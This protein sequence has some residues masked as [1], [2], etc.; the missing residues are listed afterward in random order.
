MQKTKKRSKFS[1]LYTSRKKQEYDRTFTK[2][3]KEL[4]DDAI[5][6]QMYKV[7]SMKLTKYLK[8]MKTEDYVKLKVM[9]KGLLLNNLDII[10][11]DFKI[12]Y[13]N[14]YRKMLTNLWKGI[15]DLG[16]KHQVMDYLYL[17][18]LFN[19]QLD[20]VSKFSSLVHGSL[21]AE[22]A[23]GDDA[24]TLDKKAIIRAKVNLAKLQKNL[25]QL[26]RQGIYDDV[27]SRG[28][29]IA[30]RLT[31]EQKVVFLQTIQD[32]SNY[33]KKAEVSK[34][35]F[36]ADNYIQNRIR[37]LTNDFGNQYDSYIKEQISD[38]L[39]RNIE[40]VRQIRETFTKEQTATQ[41]IYNALVDS[42]VQDRINPG[43][44]AERILRTELSIAYNFGKL[45]GF[46][47]PEDLTKRFRWN[48][49]WELESRKDD[50]QVCVPCQD[51]DGSIWTVAQ[52]LAVGTRLDRGILKYV[53]NRG[54][55]DFKNPTLPMI[56]YHPHC[57]CYWT[58][59][60]NGY[61][62]DEG[63]IDALEP[64]QPTSSVDRLTA[65]TLL[66]GA[67]VTGLLVGGTF[68]L[69]RSNAWRTFLKSGKNFIDNNETVEQVISKVK[70][71][72]NNVRDYVDDVVQKTT[73]T[74]TIVD[75]TEDFVTETV[76][77]NDYI[78]ENLDKEVADQFKE[79]VTGVV[80]SGIK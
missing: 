40:G 41:N 58:F 69:S 8:D 38:Y 11:N 35:N 32:I 48:A 15:F 79:V 28:E 45:A 13:M 1:K 26:K 33:S 16:I 65:N 59:E 53:G 75:E 50:Y 4:N 22:F 52:L 18:G 43:A 20:K 14:R 30:A 62:P 34:S 72:V 42:G 63:V 56:P 9:P 80:N 2:L 54:Q 37:V 49:D 27:F 23:E 57:N 39:S 76:V 66:G 74:T 67:A 64:M 3:Y 73:S 60:D 19:D 10:T 77:V 68:L 25:D 70:P 78:E 17:T 36:L 29:G 7:V 6:R 61:Q 31:L 46:T 47:S 55:T 24:N 51:M 21:I 12:I 5:R 44:K 71:V